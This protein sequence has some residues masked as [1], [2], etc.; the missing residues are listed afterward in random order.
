MQEKL[1]ALSKEYPVLLI[2]GPRQSGK[3]TLCRMLFP[4]K[5]YVLLE[6]P[7]IR[8]QANEDPRGFMRQL[9]DGAV[10]D[11]IQRVPE[12]LSY[13]QG[14]V[15]EK[16]SNGM[17]ILTGSSNILLMEA[18]TQTLA[19][20]VAIFSLLPLSIQET[21]NLTLL[22]SYEKRII[23]GGYPRLLADR[24][25]KDA[26]FENYIM[27]YVEKD[28]RS[29]LRIK[30]ADRFRIFLS[31]CAERIGGLLDITALSRECGI[32]T[33]TVSE[34]LS[35]L[36]AS[37]ICF[38]LQPYYNNRTKRLVKTPK[39]FFYDTGLACALL[40]ITSEARLQKDRMRGSLFENLVI[41]EEVKR[42]CNSASSDKLY[43]Y[44]TADGIEVDLVKEKGRTLYPI[45][46]KCSETFSPAWTRGIDKFKSEYQE[47]SSAGT[48]VYAGEKSF[49]FK[50][51]HIKSYLQ[52]S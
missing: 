40:G 28:V 4:N 12:L 52:E 18:I 42:K 33:K 1:L 17:F 15:D 48:I 32:S 11:E 21:R 34:W 20:R 13:I 37:F 31:L 45:E 16:E 27:T 24:M 19:G 41:L 22:D 47:M 10:I 49:A 5:P 43:F 50:D 2:Q 3:T 7:D 30:D 38:K 8:E 6:T 39:L 9:P 46:I 44:R 26:F 29:V 36:E 23:Y 25:D 51:F 35:I 14:I